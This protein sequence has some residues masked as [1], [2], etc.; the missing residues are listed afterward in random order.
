MSRLAEFPVGGI[1]SPGRLRSAG[2]RG[3]ANVISIHRH[4]RLSVAMTKQWK[5]AVH[6]ASVA[7]LQDLLTAGADIDARDEHGQTALMLSALAGHTDVV[8]FLIEHGAALDHT[9]KFGLSAL[10]LA[11]I[12]GHVE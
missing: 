2:C 6:Q 5:A 1:A 11:V 9:A 4:C 8:K 7:A 12:N 10:M 3:Q